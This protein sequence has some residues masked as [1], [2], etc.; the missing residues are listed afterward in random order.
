MLANVV[1]TQQK[2]KG[3]L[4][5]NLGTPAS[6]STRDVANYLGEFL[7]DPR[8]VD[9]PRWIW[10]P[11]LKLVIVPLRKS[12]S[13]GAYR[14]IWTAEGSPLLVNSLAIARALE[15]ELGS[16]YAVRLATR[17]GEPSIH[18]E[19][20]ALKALGV[21][22]LT[23]LPLYPQYSY[24]TTAS[25]F[26]AVQAAMKELAWQPV[27]HELQDYHDDQ[28]W[29]GA[30]ADSIRKYQAH[31]GKPD[32]LLFS[33][34][35]IPQRYVEAGD[36][37]LAQCQVGIVQIAGALGLAADDYMLTFQSRVGREPWL[38]PYTNG[39]LRDLGAS[40]V[41]RVQV[42]CPGFAADCLETLEEIAMQNKGVFLRSGGEA[43]DY[44]PALNDS[45]LHIQALAGLVRPAGKDGAGQDQSPV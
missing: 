11:L 12:R 23:V 35:G 29:V 43:L 13:A 10:L 2:M 19:L 3:V 39:V 17:Y 18:A 4:L 36:P 16:G 30:V 33:L 15:A 28:R 37:Y 45:S 9:L 26:D 27:L 31:N 34:H 7:A 25:V 41:K 40:G 32:R 1:F 42:V 20:S 8:V 21:S 5:V 24:T 14:K 22:E 38:Q 44:I 6:P